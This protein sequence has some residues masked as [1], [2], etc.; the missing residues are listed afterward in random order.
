VLPAAYI[1]RTSWVQGVA[2]ANF[3]KTMLRLGRAHGAVSVVDD[4]TGS[5]TFAFDLAPA[6]RRLA[7]TGLYGTYHLT[8]GGTCTWYEFALAIFAEAGLD[9]M[10]TP[11]D[12]ATFGAPAPRPPF[13][14]LDNLRAR[15]LGLEP[16]PDWR[17][18]LKRL[19]AELEPPAGEGG[20]A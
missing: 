8:N 16:L 1:V 17:F 18:S 7:T 6:I 2:G 9:V 15:L 4:Q 19:I 5:P 14:V 3:V 11:I 20:P 12:T 10:C 13:S